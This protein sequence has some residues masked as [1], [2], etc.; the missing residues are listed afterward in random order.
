MENSPYH[1]PTIEVKKRSD[2][3]VI[4]HILKIKSILSHLTLL[5][6]DFLNSHYPEVRELWND[7]CEY[8]KK[9]IEK[10]IL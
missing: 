2:S 4:L 10:R 8:S 5:V 9:V 1:L 3:Y 6:D 7:V